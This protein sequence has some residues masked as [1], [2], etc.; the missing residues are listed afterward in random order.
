MI[1]MVLSG[2]VACIFAI[3]IITSGILCGL[4]LTN[5]H[6]AGV[7]G[8]DCNGGNISEIDKIVIFLK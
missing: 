3:D 1:S 5:D 6:V 8:N 2:Y 4:F 7:K